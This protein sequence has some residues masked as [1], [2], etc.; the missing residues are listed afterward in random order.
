M[1][2]CCFFCRSWGVG[3]GDMKI[4]FESV[5]Q[6][7]DIL[8]NFFSEVTC[9]MHSN[10]GIFHLCNV[11]WTSVADIWYHHL[12]NCYLTMNEISVAL[13]FGH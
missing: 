11:M 4:L 6:L 8:M 2:N 5:G 9:V 13:L 3:P 7:C 1:I 12:S 10:V